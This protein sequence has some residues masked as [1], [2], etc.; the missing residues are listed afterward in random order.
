MVL[1]LAGAAGFPLLSRQLSSLSGPL[2]SLGRFFR[3]LARFFAYVAGVLPLS[4]V[5]F[6]RFFGY[7]AGLLFA[8]LAA[9]LELSRVFFPVP[10]RRVPLRLFSLLVAVYR[11][12]PGKLRHQDSR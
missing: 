8:D 2:V 1:N 11:S 4:A 7:V 6:A 5:F 10:P 12:P 9:L 3:D